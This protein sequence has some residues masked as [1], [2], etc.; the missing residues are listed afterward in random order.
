M[1]RI[2]PGTQ[3]N[4]TTLSST[5]WYEIEGLKKYIISVPTGLR[6]GLLEGKPVL[7]WVLG[8]FKKGGWAL[9]QEESDWQA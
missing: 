8:T 4:T 6:H 5:K 3:H 2:L 7:E 9:K 1:L